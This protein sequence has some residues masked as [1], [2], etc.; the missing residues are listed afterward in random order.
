MNPIIT[1][2]KPIYRSLT[3]LIITINHYGS[4]TTHLNELF[5]LPIILQV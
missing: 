2:L 4:L 1:P 3:A 5:K